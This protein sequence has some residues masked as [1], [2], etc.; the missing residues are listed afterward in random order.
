MP[1]PLA[2]QQKAR[3]LASAGRAQLAP[4]VGD[5]LVHRLGRD[6]ELTRDFL[7][8]TMLRHH[9]KRLAFARGK[10]VDRRGRKRTGF[11]H[12]WH[13]NVAVVRPSIFNSGFTC[14]TQRLTPSTSPSEPV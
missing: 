2:G 6:A 10:A 3:R 14:L 13:V 5:M 8:L 12:V 7:G 4:G 11:A 9:A 1:A